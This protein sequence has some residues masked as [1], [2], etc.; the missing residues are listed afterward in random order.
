MSHRVY[1]FILLDACC[2]LLTVVAIGLTECVCRE[3]YWPLFS[4]WLLKCCGPTPRM[5]SWLITNLLQLSV[6]GTI[7]GR[8]IFDETTPDTE[9]STTVM[10]QSMLV[11]VV[12]KLVSNSVCMI[13]LLCIILQ[14]HFFFCTLNCIFAGLSVQLIR[15]FASPVI[16]NKLPSIWVKARMCTMHNVSVLPSHQWVSDLPLLAN[17]ILCAES[18]F[19]R[20]KLN[21]GSRLCG[22]IQQWPLE[23]HCRI[24]VL[25]I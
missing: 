15:V 12:L 1:C 19:P 10:W 8:L 7:N 2:V 18:Y 5:K 16:G 11:I 22:A 6:K 24:I 4:L 20:I 13:G 21:I 25:G 14:E 23:C 3:C 17:L 9:G